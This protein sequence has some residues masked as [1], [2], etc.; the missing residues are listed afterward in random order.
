MVGTV[1]EVGA[2]IMAGAEVA[3]AGELERLR[4]ALW[5]RALTIIIAIAATITPITH[6]TTVPST[7][8]TII[9]DLRWRPLGQIE[10]H[11]KNEP[12]QM[13]AGEVGHGGDGRIGS[14]SR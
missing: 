10:R 2:I 8:L 7:S 13:K 1:T 14:Q 12:R 11:R 5:P 4:L 9:I 6:L 3:G